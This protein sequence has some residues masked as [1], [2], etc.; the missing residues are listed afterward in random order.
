MR[1]AGFWCG[2]ALWLCAG[3]NLVVHA[4]ERPALEEAVMEVSVNGQSASDMLIVL[5][6]QSAGLWLDDEDL[7]RLHLRLPDATPRL[8]ESRRYY[9]VSALPGSRVQFD[10]AAG[11]VLI[12]V[13]ADAFL[14]TH[15]SAPGRTGP[16]IT[17]SE[18][19]GFLNYQLSSQRYSNENLTGGT[20]ELGVFDAVGVLTG[21]AV[22]R[23]DDG[24][25]A[26]VRLDTTF[27]KE[28]PARLETLELGDAITDPG[29]WG[30]AVRFGGIH[31][32]TNFGLRP[33]MLTTPLL[34][35]S[36]TAVLPSTVDVFVNNQKVSSQNLP[37]GPFIVDQLPAITG[38]GDVTLVVR[39]ALG[40][41]Q[42]ITQPFYASASLLAPGLSK[43]E[44]DLG[45]ARNDYSLA[46]DRYAGLTGSATYQR[47]I[48]S[49]LT[50]EAHGEF[51][52]AQ[53]YAAGVDL[54][55]AVSH[56]G[57]VSATV[58]EGGGNGRSGVLSSLGYAWQAQWFNFSVSKSVASSG[59]QQISDVAASSGQFK[60]RNLAEVG[61]NLSHGS[62]LQLAYA[63]ETFDGQPQLKTV[64]AAYSKQLP[65][66][67][68]LSLSATRTISTQTASSLYL[69]ITIPLGGRKSVTTGGTLGRGAGAPPDEANG[70]LVQSPPIGPGFGYRL[71]ETSGDNYTADGR[72]QTGAGDL[73]AMAVRNAGI[74][75]QS[76][77]WS[78][79]ATLLDGQLRVARQVT[80]SFAVVDVAGLPGVPVYIDNQK[81]AE[82]DPSGKAL[83]HDL[84]PYQINRISIDPLDLPLD[85]SIDSKT[86]EVAPAFRSGVVLRF[87]V[88]KIRAGIFRLIT[89][90]GTAV[91]AGARVKFQGELVPVALDGRVYVTG[92][93]HGFS[94]TAT[95][96]THTCSF[97]VA[98]PPAGDPQPDMGT[99]VCSEQTAAGVTP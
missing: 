12:T 14:A 54:A 57:I 80:D 73:E 23:A 62:S 95:W 6:D 84:L 77:Q 96:A 69:F 89:R 68:T 25:T 82:T 28:F 58:A 24:N 26:L 66:Q 4:E 8:Y 90:D 13:A 53:A 76:V 40:Q 49:A 65:D 88:R 59:Y 94:A 85:T 1:A 61:V 52:G 78:G 44:M 36:G 27:T 32:G 29:N 98:T 34:A 30:S 9:P 56:Y 99:I 7:A 33:D 37:P 15:L 72:W 20:V 47:G 83:L 86:M 63:D 92:F 2:L 71:G 21:T 35:A 87:P 79:A 81:V 42:V 39:N 48:N 38:S 43:Y 46:S 75:G 50:V 10:E 5:R 91:P 16:S 41:Q 18:L 60:Q 93:D 74:S 97:H 3:T 11:R 51:L 31:W 67:I 22:A 19:G 64:S 70:M 55:A 45:V 17:P